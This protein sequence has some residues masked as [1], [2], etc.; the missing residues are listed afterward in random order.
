MKA[1]HVV[2]V[3]CVLSMG[4]HSAFSQGS[5]GVEVSTGVC[6]ISGIS[7]SAE[8]FHPLFL[9]QFYGL[10]GVSTFTQTGSGEI[11]FQRFFFGIQIGDYFFVAPKLSFNFASNRSSFGA[12]REMFLSWGLEAGLMIHPSHLIAFGFK[13]A[14]DRGP[15]DPSADVHRPIEINSISLLVRLKPIN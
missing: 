1:W 7:Y 15:E 13:V 5:R 9:S 4:T 14:Y 11:Q 8:Y 12:N 6:D 10:G 3:A 2:L